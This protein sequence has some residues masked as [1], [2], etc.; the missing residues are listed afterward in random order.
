MDPLMSFLGSLNRKFNKMFEGHV[1]AHEDGDCLVLTGELQR[2]S[3]V[4]L[5]GMIAVRKTPYF[6]LI[7]DIV[8]TGE[9]RAP[10][11]KPRIEDNTLDF[12]EPDVLIIGGGVIGCAIARELSRYKLNVLLV[13]KE[14]DVA[15]Q[16]SGRNDGMIHSGIDLKKGSQKYKY[17]KLG[18]PMFDKLC[19]ELGIDFD[20]CGQ[21]LCFAN[22][23][24]EPLM[25]LSL[26]YWYWLGLRG[27]KVVKRDE[28]YEVEPAINPNIR[29]ALFFPATGVLCPFSLTVAYAENAAQ[30]GVNISFDTMV[31]GMVTEDGVIKSVKTNRGT[32]QPKVVVNAAG[33]F[34]DDIA[35]LASDRFYSIHPRKGTTAILD[36]KYADDLV[37]TTISSLGT[38]NTKKKHTKGGGIIRTID[39]NI[40]VGPDAVE[41]RHKEDFSTNINNIKDMFAA[42]A[43]TCPELDEKQIITYFSGI[44]AATYE[45]DFIIS[46]G[47]Y[48]SNMVHAAGIQSP[49][50]T[51]APAISLDVVN[52][53]LDMF[54]GED[55]V[56]NNPDFNPI[57]TPPPC[58]R[59]MDEDARA[60]FIETNPDYGIIICRCEEISKGEIL[61]ALRRNVKCN[62]ID[63][64]KRRVRPGMG[65]CQGSFCGPQVLEII[66]AEKRAL[67]QNVRKSG[68]G[69]EILYGTSNSILEKRG[70]AASAS[71]FR[72]SKIDSE[73]EELLRKRA[74]E[75]FSASRS[76]QKDGGDDDYDD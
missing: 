71:A 72:G 68:I 55:Y 35:A 32:I 42:Q 22:R 31:T 3:D 34:C 4:V 41:T 74:K 36:K 39:G 10:M 15:V 20:R 13:E 25:F 18:N 51:A 27:V 12:E 30:N 6:G 76:D 38:A 33:V 58:P 9:P 59:E 14:H 19:A 64:V 26:I 56:E 43:R 24:W 62:S 65:R 54:G 69:S 5:A 57:R 75:R 8:C 73:T 17:N 2:W 70:A 49:G 28:L 11:R 23:L 46:K 52:M 61:N 40:L 67:Q 21:Y 47:R 48:V 53:V 37:Q 44:R 66:A 50:L 16:T 29:S 7:N 60:E 45:E 63:G 1:E